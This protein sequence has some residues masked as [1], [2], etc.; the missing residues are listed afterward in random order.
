[1]G[2]IG[3]FGG[4]VDASGL[5][6]NLGIRPEPVKSHEHA[7]AETITRPWDD[8]EKAAL[9]CL[10]LYDFDTVLFPFNWHMHMAR[11]MGAR[12]IKAAKERGRGVLFPAVD[13]FS[14]VQANRKEAPGAGDSAV[15][16]TVSP[17]RFR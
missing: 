10:E 5:L 12:L 8:S 16:R 13:P 6:S 7:D 3:I 11:G 1:M 17:I 9:R 4:K 14:P 2:S 15:S